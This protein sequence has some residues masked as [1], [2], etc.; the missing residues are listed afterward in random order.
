VPA[1]TAPIGINVL[2]RLIAMSG[3]V[4]MVTREHRV[5]CGQ[6]GSNVI[7][8]HFTGNWSWGSRAHKKAATQ[9]STGGP[10]SVKTRPT[11]SLFGSIPSG[12][13]SQRRAAIRVGIKGRPVCT[14]RPLRRIAIS[15]VR[16]PFAD[17]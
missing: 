15:L 1:E 11:L 5:R 10:G 6:A 12:L 4:E 3:L 2:R 14:V 16:E 17:R 13:V 7:C 8:R 9:T